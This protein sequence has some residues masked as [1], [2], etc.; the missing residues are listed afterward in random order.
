MGV[1]IRGKWYWY[2][3]V[4]KG[5]R[6]R[7]PLS[8]RKGQEGLL[9]ERVK[10]LDDQLTARALGLH[11]PAGGDILFSE[12]VERFLKKKSYAKSI[13][14]MRERLDI[15][16]SLWPDLP[17]SH[18]TPT[19]IQGLE[20]KLFARESKRGKLSGAT[21]NRYASL[22]RNLWNSA[23]EDR[24]ATENPWR[25]YKP[26]AEGG[27]R[28]ALTDGEL[29]AILSEAA[30]R[31]ANPT[32]AIDPVIHDL[33]LFAL[34]TGLRVSE[35]LNLRRQYIQGITLSLPI[36]A[37]KSRRRGIS[38][39]ASRERTLALSPLARDIIAR[40]P[41][42]GAYVFP[43][44][45]RHPNAVTRVVEH[46]RQATGFKDWSFHS[47]RHTASTFIAGHSSLA[48]AR[49]ILG[50]ADIKTTLRYTHPGEA[51][52]RRAVTKLATHI[53]N[54]SRKS[55]KRKAE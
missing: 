50:H 31:Q 29:E 14:E 9:S 33:M 30:R 22:L 37:V 12:Y 53:S 38:R 39:D 36:T 11:P 13:G 40:Q 4:I 51:E 27:S 35:I 34:A 20:E 43:A 3:R 25:S 41:D 5:R 49:G 24:E 21:V 6:Y 18:Y 2:L 15:V 16:R 26:Y 19:H 55:L 48:A 1:Y 17:L 10:K 46:I 28:R 47:F 45:R 42:D 23:I 52:N 32:L 7:L 44:H 8:V 54:L